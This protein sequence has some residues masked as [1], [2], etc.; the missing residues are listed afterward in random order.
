MGE[1]ARAVTARAAP[2][3]R[4]GPLCTPPSGAGT[5]LCLL[6]SMEIPFISF[7]SASSP[8][9]FY[10]WSCFRFP[11]KL[12]EGAESPTWPG[13]THA[14]PPRYQRPA[15]EGTFVPTCEPVMICH[16]RPRQESLL[17]LAFRGYGHVRK[18]TC[19]ALWYHTEWLRCPESP[20]HSA[21]SSLPTFWQPP[22]VQ[23]RERPTPP[24]PT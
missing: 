2:G 23:N 15:P 21:R 7:T 12:T 24:A 16:H 1:R 10:L 14:Q 19:P 13:P 4:V 5:L 22:G 9:G 8:L 11:E 6:A 20:L 3:S 17:V 18:D